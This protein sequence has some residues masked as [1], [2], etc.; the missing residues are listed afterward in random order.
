MSNTCNRI[1]FRSLNT[2]AALFPNSDFHWRVLQSKRQLEIVVIVIV[3]R[4]CIWSWMI[5][6]VWR[7]P[8]MSMVM[9][10]VV[11]RFVVMDVDVYFIVSAVAAAE[12]PLIDG[13]YFK[14]DWF[15]CRFLPLRRMPFFIFGVDHGTG[16]ASVWWWCCCCW[17]R[18]QFQFPSEL[19]KYLLL[20]SIWISS[21][22][23]DCETCA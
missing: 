10:D 1:C 15:R 9:I 12:F 6:A 16:I 3:V 20:G 7:D 23:I 19:F 17:L 5:D 21:R 22:T 14:D 4:W 13:Q 18:F 8:L 2:T 11:W